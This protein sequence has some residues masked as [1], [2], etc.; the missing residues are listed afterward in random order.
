M[1]V[2][3]RSDTFTKIVAIVAQHLSCD[4]A[5]IIPETRLEDLGA[6]EF[7]VLELVMK[8]EDECGVIISDDDSAQFDS[9]QDVIDC[10][11]AKQ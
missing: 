10:I 6:D 4:A 2:P 9:L 3:T 1:T 8:W 11:A 7:D 5:V